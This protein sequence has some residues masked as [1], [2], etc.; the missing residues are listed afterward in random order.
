MEGEAERRVGM[1]KWRTID[2]ESVFLS[3]QQGNA[4]APH[5]YKYKWSKPW[6]FF[7]TSFG[8]S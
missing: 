3:S 7:K 6:L 1:K 4:I 2:D 5:P 8:G